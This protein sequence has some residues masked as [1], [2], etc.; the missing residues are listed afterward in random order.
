MVATFTTWE[1][2]TRQRQK[3]NT[4]RLFLVHPRF[5]VDS[6]TFSSIKKNNKSSLFFFSHSSCVE[7]LNS[8]STL[9]FIHLFIFLS[10]NKTKFKKN[11]HLNYQMA[12]EKIALHSLCIPSCIST[13]YFYD[14]LYYSPFKTTIRLCINTFSYK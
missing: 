1:V 10:S 3:K 7:I 11:L 4:Q 9:I 13:F 6:G 2:D 12:K 8:L 5:Y 14:K